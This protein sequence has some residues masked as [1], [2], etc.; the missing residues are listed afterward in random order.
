MA[1]IYD[2]DPI[3][4]IEKIAEELKKIEAIKPLPW[5]SY[6]K[7]GVHKERPPI[8]KD[9]WYIRA[10]SLLRAIYKLGPIGV[11]KLRTKYG[12]KK[13]SGVKTEHFYK[14]SGSIIR[15]ILQ[16]LEKAELVKK[17]AKKVHKG[18]LI[19]QKGKSLLDKTASMIIGKKPKK[20]EKQEETSPLET[21]NKEEI[22][23]EKFTEEIKSKEKP[24]KVPSAE[25]LAKKKK[26]G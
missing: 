15:K 1:T 22:S 5:A 11:S 19:T 24:A 7:T 2:V 9:W 8:R 14:G 6:V 21:H 3:E 16:Q 17:E 23:T 4:H 20:A 18:R 12:G 25:E 10:A 13:S 26:D